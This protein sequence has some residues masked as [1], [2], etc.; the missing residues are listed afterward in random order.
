MVAA[1]TTRTNGFAELAYVGERPWHGTGQQLIRGQTIEQWKVAAGMDWRVCRSRVRFGEGANQQVMDDQHVLFRSDTKLPLGI[2]SDKY[3]VV[4][5]GETLEFFRDL[6]GANG[7]ELETAGTLFDGRRF[8][9]LA[10]IGEEAV[11][12]G[13]DVMKG[14]LLCSS[15][16]DGT[17]ATNVRNTAVRV[18]CNNT[19][20]AALGG[21]AGVTITHRS[22]FNHEAVKDQLG[23]ARGSFREFIVKARALAQRPIHDVAAREFVG[24]LLLATKTV[25]S[26]SV[27]GAQE[28]K[29]FG[30]IMELFRGLGRGAT[31]G[32][33]DGTA[34]G[35]VNAVTEYVD[36]HARARSA[37]HLLNSAW[38]GP[39]EALKNAAF[40]KA[41]ALV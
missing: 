41:L 3:K 11:V 32:S 27:A 19:L 8:W 15:S 20:T 25:T 4:Q 31:L 28:T 18:V 37:S 2:V 30:R 38:F 26:D 12:S 22:R 1:V 7:F 21:R 36:H 24:E 9:A 5:P 33:S 39:G 23:L 35:V 6:V 17:L 10:A 40:A 14:Y 16:A 34:W 29:Q 13:H